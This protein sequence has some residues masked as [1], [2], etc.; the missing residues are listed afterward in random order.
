MALKISSLLFADDVRNEEG[1][2]LS[3]MGLYNEKIVFGSAGMPV[4]WPV[5]TRLATFIRVE[6]LATDAKPDAFKFELLLNGKVLVQ[7]DGKISVPKHS[8]MVNLSIK[9]DGV[10]L[11]PGNLGVKLTLSADGKPVL[12][13]MMPSALAVEGP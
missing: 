5:S 9:G 10:P 11:Q 1:K 8:T 13:E 4:K 12:E 7:V 3:L 2:K 6:M